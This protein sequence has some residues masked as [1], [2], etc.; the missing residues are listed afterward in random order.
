MN[1][2]YLLFTSSG[3]GSCFDSGSTECAY[4]YYCAYHSSFGSPS[5][6]YGNEP[7]GD[8]NTCNSVTVFPTRADADTAAT[9]AS[10]EIS[11]AITDPL[12]NAWYDSSGSEIGDKCAYNYGTNTWDSGKANQN[13]GLFLEVQQEFDNHAN[14][15]IGGCVQYGP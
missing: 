3:E 1:K 4:T 2:M 11:E 5:V 9:A 14:L 13:W 7:Y 10:H 12:G 15:G 6:I 8:P